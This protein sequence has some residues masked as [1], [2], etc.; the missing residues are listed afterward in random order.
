MALVIVSLSLIHSSN[1]Y[2]GN[3]KQKNVSFLFPTMQKP[4]TIPSHDT[5]INSSPI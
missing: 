3:L 1:E 2:D 5:L 4:P